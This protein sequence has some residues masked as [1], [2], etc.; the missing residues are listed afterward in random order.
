MEMPEVVAQVITRYDKCT[1]CGLNCKKGNQV[2]YACNPNVKQIKNERAKA[3]LKTDKGKVNNRKNNKKWRTTRAAAID[4]VKQGE[5][6]KKNDP[7]AF[8]AVPDVKPLIPEEED[9]EDNIFDE[10]D[11]SIGSD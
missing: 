3:W 6:K 10:E 7:A 4:F 5:E 2:C 1:I 8:V 11:D 9:L